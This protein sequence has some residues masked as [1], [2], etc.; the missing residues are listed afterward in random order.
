MFS[1]DEM[2]FS[3]LI[4]S[5]FLKRTGKGLIFSS[6]DLDLLLKWEESGCSVGTICKGIDA[7]VERSNRTP[8]DL[9][10]CR[11]FIEEMMGPKKPFKL[12]ASSP[13]IIPL[14]EASV[15]PPPDDRDA[16]L[17]MV[18]RY[19]QKSSNDRF[20]ELYAQ[21]L[22]LLGDPNVE[23][24]VFEF[25]DKFYQ[26]AFFALA[27]PLQREIDE[28]INRTLGPVLSTMSPKARKAT[29]KAKRR[30]LLERKMSPANE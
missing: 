19:A 13:Q 8:R 22:K 7:A 12:H 20:Q 28:E 18:K 26:N 14:E 24:D 11:K 4:Q 9:F 15:P 16:L 30:A 27:D 23:I 21:S 17:V 10:A 6:R 1:N 3:E 2:N 25:E 29:I 5:Y